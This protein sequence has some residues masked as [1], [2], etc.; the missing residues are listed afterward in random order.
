[1]FSKKSSSVGSGENAC[2]SPQ[3]VLER[4]NVQQID[5]KQISRLGS[6]NIDWAAQVMNLPNIAGLNILD[7][8]IVLNL[9]ASAVQTL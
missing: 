3:R 2:K 6:I 7:G 1:M 4:S 8:I 5:L 9:S